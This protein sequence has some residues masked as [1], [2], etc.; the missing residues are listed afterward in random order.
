MQKYSCRHIKLQ[1]VE[2]AFS[3]FFPLQRIG[4]I[5][6]L[7]QESYETFSGKLELCF[8][9][10]AEGTE[11]TDVVNGVACKTPF[12]NIFLKIPTMHQYSMCDSLRDVI[13]F[14]YDASLYERMLACGLISP[15]YIWHFQMTR[16]LASIFG[17]IRELCEH[18]LEYGVVDQLDLLALQLFQNVLLKRVHPA[19]NVYEQS[20][21]A[22]IRRIASYLQLNF[23][24]AVSLE[25]LYKRNGFSRRS[26]FRHWNQ[27]YPVSPWQ[28]IQ[29]LKL[30]YA[31]NRL[32]ETS[33]PIGEIC[34]ELNF[35]N[36]H[37][38]SSLFKKRF[39]ITPMQFRK[40]QSLRETD[41]GAN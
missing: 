8:R 6:N 32:R 33:M 36:Q 1:A 13:Y 11:M 10:S 7:K 29:E 30:D 14:Y 5:E 12:P 21:E 41:A 27:Y 2:R 20:V 28:Y 3:G 19:G 23:N 26:F 24:R 16:E 4:F 25:E 39:G 35:K 37:Y 31:C 22:R 15:P 9:F 38:I 40:E 18:V 17:R 34:S